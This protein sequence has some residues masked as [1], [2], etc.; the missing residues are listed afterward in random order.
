MAHSKGDDDRPKELVAQFWERD[1]LSRFQREEPTVYGEYEQAALKRIDAAVET[2]LAAPYPELPKAIPTEV[3]PLAWHRPEYTE[4]R[5]LNEL[6]RD[7]FAQNMGQN[8]RIV[9]IG[10][11]ICDPYGGAF[12][13]TRGLSSAY[14]DRVWGTSIS[15]A[16]IVGIGNGL[17]L[18]GM[19][20]VCEIMFGDFMPLAFDQILNHAAKFPGMYN[21]Q[22][23]NPLIVRSPMGGGRG[24]GPTHSQSLEKHF[25]GIPHTIV[26]SVNHRYNP[27]DLYDTLF[28]EIE[29]PALV[30]EN[31]L[32]YARH[33][34]SETE[35]GFMLEH[36]DETWPTVR[37]R[38]E[39]P[40]DI[41]LLC[42]GGSLACAEKA[43]A[44]AFDREEIVSEIICPVRLYPLDI[45]AVVDSLKQSGLLL[46][47]E[48]GYSFA[49]WGSEVIA[50]LTE[51]DPSLLRAVRRV[52]LPE[53]PIPCSGPLEAQAL[54]NPDKVLNRIKEMFSH[55]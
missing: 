13:V 31:K 49:A 54:P 30:F 33:L 51:Y 48:E 42:Y 2:A 6:L 45:R 19:I 41:T 18:H 50:R 11:D 28:R 36:S 15:E 53:Y 35:P 55:E 16:A 9:M 14:P 26:L 52:S 44:L 23:Q 21:H 20:P 1:A 25:L 43:Q 4:K 46:I 22:V 3:G 37:V 27:A 47:I 7:C 17:S 34:S 5:R 39:S 10:E 24:Y 38:P 40:P 29:G 12:K 32:L 8:E